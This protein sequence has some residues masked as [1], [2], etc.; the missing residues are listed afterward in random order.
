M[1]TNKFEVV[2]TS[3]STDKFALMK[4]LRIVANLELRQASAL[5]ALI[6]TSG[7]IVLAAGID[8]SIAE[9]IST[10]LQNTGA[11]ATIRESS[12]TVPML[13]F[14]DVNKKYKEGAIFGINEEKA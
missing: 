4:A 10:L 8:Q 1:D 9:H 13:C 5:T 11:T 6:E 14:P 12:I 2:I 7:N 3:V